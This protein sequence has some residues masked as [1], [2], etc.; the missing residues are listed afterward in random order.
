MPR[1]VSL[2]GGGATPTSLVAL[3]LLLF[4]LLSPHILLE[5]AVDHLEL[6]LDTGG[7]PH[8]GSHALLG[9]QVGDLALLLGQP[10]LLVDA[11]GERQKSE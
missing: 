8:A 10:G 5:A 3:F 2:A 11:A 7:T 6:A 4:A 1:A 9:H